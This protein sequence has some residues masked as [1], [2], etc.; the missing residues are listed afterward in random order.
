MDDNWELLVTPEDKKLYTD[1]AYTL[2]QQMRCCGFTEA[3]RIGKRKNLPLGYTGL[4]CIHCYGGYGSGRYFPSSVK[5]M[6]DSSKTL[7]VIH[8][9]VMKCLKCPQNIKDQLEDLRERHDDDRATKKFGSQ[10]AFFQKIWERLHKEDRNKD[11]DT[12]SG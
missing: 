6:A 8:S 3:D 11:S 1:F 7:N 4:A 2:L 9:H 10:R 12:T 5:T